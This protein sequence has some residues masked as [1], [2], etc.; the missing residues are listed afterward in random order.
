[1]DQ[2]KEKAGDL[3]EQ[4]KGKAQDALSEQKERAT[5]ALGGVA[6]A[7]H[8]TSD[9]LRENE[10]DAFAQYAAMAAEQV[11]RFTHAIR[12]RSVGDLLDQAEGFAR[13]EPGLFLGGAFLLGVFGARFLKASQPRAQ[14]AGFAGTGGAPTGGFA[15]AGTL[16]RPSSGPPTFGGGSLGGSTGASGAGAR[17][18][19]GARPEDLNPA[20]RVLH[21]AGGEMPQPPEGVSGASAS[22]QPNA[23]P[24]K[25]PSL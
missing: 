13:R 5:G 2:A 11:E 16:Y 12:E 4:A 22:G 19:P 10:Q 14:A 23:D 15:S 20:A 17:S 24:S 25:P 7:L 3:A 9:T 18:G 6:D 8:A 21:T 1:M